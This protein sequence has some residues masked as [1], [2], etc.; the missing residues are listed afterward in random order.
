M[1]KTDEENIVALI[2]K[3]LSIENNLISVNSSIDNVEEWDS[4]GHLSILEA[5]DQ[6]FDGK[7]VNIKELAS[8][9]S[10]KDILF[11]LK[12]NSLL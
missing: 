9:K 10:V 5:L 6:H 11:I 12:K 1:K 3:A 2:S 4:L 8:T 7:V